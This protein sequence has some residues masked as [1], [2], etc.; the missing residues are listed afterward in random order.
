MKAMDEFGSVL[1]MA[2]LV[3]GLCAGVDG[4]TSAAE[5]GSARP[6]PSY[7]GY[8]A[9]KSI[10]F[11]KHENADPAFSVEWAAAVLAASTDTGN[12][13]RFAEGRPLPVAR[14][15]RRSW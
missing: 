9:D 3:L 13:A 15:D 1:A 7:P 14:Q 6:V 11:A 8:G 12:G 10:Q 5:T 2:T 4:I